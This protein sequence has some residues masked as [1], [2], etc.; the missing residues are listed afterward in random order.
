M[1]ENLRRNAYIRDNSEA[2]QPE[3]FADIST[4][5]ASLAIQ[6]LTEECRKFLGVH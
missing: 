3:N 2:F 5:K 4:Q 6:A 1:D